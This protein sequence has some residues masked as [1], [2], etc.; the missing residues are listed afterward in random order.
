MWIQKF[1]KIKE[2]TISYWENEGKSD[3]TIVFLPGGNSSGIHLKHLDEEL[4]PNIRF[5]VPD[6]PGRGGS[7][8]LPVNSSI[9]NIAKYLLSLFEHLKI[10]DFTLVGHSFGWAIAD[11]IIRQNQNLKIK[12]LVFI[13]PGEFIWHPFRL[14]L[15]I[16]F[17][18]PMHSQTLR[19]FF[20]F[21]I[22]KVLHI[23]KYESISKD[24]LLD[25]GQQWMSVLDFQICDSILN[26]PVI[27][28][29]SLH[30]GVIDR[31]SMKKIKAVYPNF[32]EI[33]L[34]IPHVFYYWQASG[35]VLFKA[36]GKE[37]GYA[38]LR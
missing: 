38:I 26:I 15:K 36:I 37:L 34:D 27:I 4:N 22:C 10:N 7:D 3:K 35:A 1:C 6:Y 16:L 18:L 19:E 21:V 24:K 5:I 20:W 14:P 33:F 31:E 2:I 32:K 13:D 30:D 25:L 29:R 11:Q 17:F 12:H 23:F 9:E 28:T 8:S